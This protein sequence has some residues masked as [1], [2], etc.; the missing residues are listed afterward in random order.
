MTENS[1]D[2]YLYEVAVNSTIT[3]EDKLY[4]ALVIKDYIDD[5][6]ASSDI[7]RIWRDEYS[8]LYQPV[9]IDINWLLSDTT[10]VYSIKVKSFVIE[11][12]II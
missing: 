1:Y 2:R 4:L 12:I 8:R 6:D 10:N 3:D 7:L 11:S 9:N 5:N